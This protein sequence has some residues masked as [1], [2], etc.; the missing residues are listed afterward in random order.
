MPSRL[1]FVRNVAQ[2]SS[3]GHVMSE[4]ACEC[5][6]TTVVQT[7][8]AIKGL[9]QSCGCLRCDGKPNLKHGMH[10]TATYCSWHAMKRR[11]ECPEDKD[12]PRYGAVGI[13]VTP[14]W[15]DFAN[16]F[17]DMGER[18][19]GTTLDRIDGTKGYEPGNCRW[20]TIREQNRNTKCFTVV[21]TPIGVVGLVD[22]AA[23]LGISNG[24]AHLRLKRGKLEGCTRL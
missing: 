14:Q 2:R 18:R 13:R 22:Y 11:C 10:G 24:A 21:S 17:R 4:W 19:P 5:G 7:R 8:Y 23:H 20:A 3:D 12:Y 15:F 1:T 6:N 16:F 9:T